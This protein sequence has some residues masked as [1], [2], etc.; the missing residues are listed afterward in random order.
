MIYIHYLP[1]YQINC[2]LLRSRGQTEYTD[3]FIILC[4]FI[5]FSQSYKESLEGVWKDHGCQIRSDFVQKENR[6]KLTQIPAIIVVKKLVCHDQIRL[7]NEDDLDVGLTIAIG[8][9]CKA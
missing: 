6:K 5:H 3:G 9:E 1:Q 2:S 7:C 4:S 8:G